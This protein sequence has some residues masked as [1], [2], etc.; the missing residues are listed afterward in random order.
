MAAPKISYKKKYEEKLGF[1]ESSII[2]RKFQFVT[3]T[4]KVFST[5]HWI[6]IS[7]PLILLL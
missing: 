5:A 3:H 4:K 2:C 1:L 7:A 6:L